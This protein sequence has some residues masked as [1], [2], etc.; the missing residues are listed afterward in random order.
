MMLHNDRRLTTPEGKKTPI[1]I[2]AILNETDWMN[3]CTTFSLSISCPCHFLMRAFQ[4]KGTGSWV[5]RKCVTV[6]S[7]AAA[8]LLSCCLIFSVSKMP[9]LKDIYN[10][11][12]TIFFNF[13]LLFGKWHHINR[14]TME[15]FFITINLFH[16]CCDI[17]I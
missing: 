1:N 2:K 10:K 15:I 17:C 11:K 13:P 12:R 6:W 9:H 16:Q 4:C 3:E 5:Q 7:A 8:G 14:N